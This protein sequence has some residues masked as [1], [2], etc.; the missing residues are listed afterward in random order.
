MGTTP[1]PAL[2][3]PR[4]FLPTLD[5]YVCVGVYVRMFACHG[6]YSYLLG[7]SKAVIASIDAAMVRG[8]PLKAYTHDSPRL[9]K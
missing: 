1:A 9:L 4:P 7:H 3:H 6:F 8:A 5:A 2:T